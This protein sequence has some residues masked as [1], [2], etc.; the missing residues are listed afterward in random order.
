MPQLLNTAKFLLFCRRYRYSDILVCFVLV[1]IGSVC[2]HVHA[3]ERV[4]IQGSL[5]G[6]HTGRQAPPYFKKGERAVLRFAGTWSPPRKSMWLWID[7]YNRVAVR[8]SPENGKRRIS[9][10]T[11]AACARENHIVLLDS[12]GKELDRVSFM[13]VPDRNPFDNYEVML[14]NSSSIDRRLQEALRQTG[15]SAAGIINPAGSRTDPGLFAQIVHRKA[16]YPSIS[17]S[18]K[19]AV[20]FSSYLEARGS[21]PVTYTSLR[22]YIIRKPCFS[23]PAV[24]ESWH[25]GIGRNIS[26]SFS[27]RPLVYCF[28]D[29]IRLAGNTIPYDCCHS[30]F[31]LNKFREHL[32]KQ[33][34]VLKALN[35]QWGTSFSSW[36]KVRPD[37]V[38]QAKCR[39][40]PH[41][42]PLYTGTAKTPDRILMPDEQAD[43]GKENFSAWCD[44]RSFMDEV[45]AGTL[46]R[47][48]AYIRKS[49]PDGIGGAAGLSPPSAFSGAD[50]WLQQTALDWIET[51]PGFDTVSLVRSWNPGC[52]TVVR[53]TDEIPET[54]RRMWAGLFNGGDGIILRKSSALF[55]GNMHTISNRAASIRKHAVEFQRGIASLLMDIPVYE[56]PVGIYYSQKSIQVGFMLDT[57]MDGTEWIARA[58]SKQGGGGTYLSAVSG[59]AQAAG[60]IGLTSKYVSYAQAAEGM[61][62]KMDLKVL[63]LPKVFAMSYREAEQIRSFVKN[64]GTV[65]ADNACATFDGHGKRLKKGL[66]DGLFGIKRKNFRLT[67]RNGTVRRSTSAPAVL[68]NKD[69]ALLKG[70]SSGG[71]FIVTEPGIECTQGTALVKAGSIPAVIINRTG[72]GFTCYLNISYASYVH[73]LTSSAQVRPL[74]IL[75]KNLCTQSG[76]A[77]RLCVSWENKGVRSARIT[78]FR[79]GNMCRQMQKIIT[80]PGELP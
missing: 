33:Y 70:I 22:P 35:V 75:L 63:I 78:E 64:G 47:M 16:A 80:D 8:L 48:T 62:R 21:N 65:I 67:E 46:R 58:R 6:I 39:Q 69:H 68:Q 9:L 44:H 37:T 59:F 73:S 20:R 71:R 36:N 19:G 55:A 50:W 17:A 25:S 11:S 79:D 34:L 76:A 4:A 43:P 53:D 12:K 27:M 56:D 10:D 77:P 49:A 57:E 38:D 40:N 7:S 26:G 42:I 18:A 14:W 32:K 29:G 24:I 28:G 61:L 66:L 45:W 23:D 15:I 52:R 30:T 74:C 5:N 3:Q 72:R 1:C 51:A 13:V 2:R 60:D 41:Y 31:C 54:V